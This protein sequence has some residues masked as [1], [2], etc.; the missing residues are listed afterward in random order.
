MLSILRTRSGLTGPDRYVS[1]DKSISYFLCKHKNMYETKTILVE[2]VED[3][4]LYEMAC[5]FAGV[6]N[7]IEIRSVGG[8]GE[9]T[10]ALKVIVSLGQHL[11]TIAVIRD[12]DDDPKAAFQS[13]CDAMKNAGLPYPALPG[14]LSPER[15]GKSTAVLIVPPDKPG[16][17]ESICWSSLSEHPIVAC[18]EEFL[19]SAQT[20]D[21]PL[22][23]PWPA[24]GSLTVYIVNVASRQVH[25]DFPV[26]C[27]KSRA[28]LEY[29]SVF[30][31]I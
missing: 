17:I 21:P 16:C 22:N 29:E 23:P 1:L 10:N 5:K 15:E 28:F 27:P 26:R 19:L 25:P 30:E 20:N 6:S 3:G 11:Q 31:I 13:V 12:A 4:R 24:I 2:G 8:K 9:F 7:K 18:G 14:D